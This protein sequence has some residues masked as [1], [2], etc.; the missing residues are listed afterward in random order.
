MS[1]K[2]TLSA[3]A[4]NGFRKGVKESANLIGITI[5]PKGQNVRLNGKVTNDGVSIARE[6]RFKDPLKNDGARSVIELTDKIS[7]EAGDATT[8]GTVIYESLLEEGMKKINLGPS[9]ILMRKGME[10]GLKDAVSF[11]KEMS[12]PVEKEQLKYVASVSGE[13]EEIGSI[14]ADMVQRVGSDGVITLEESHEFGLSS[15]IFQGFQFDKGYVSR[16]MATDDKQSEAIFE[17]VPILVTDQKLG[18]LDLFHAEG[19]P[20]KLI[21]KLINQKVKEL[22]IIAED[23]DPL[24]LSN[25]F[26]NRMLGI[27]KAL[28][29]KAPG[30]GDRKSEFLE[31]IAIVTGGTFFN[32]ARGIKIEDIEPEQL[33]GS[34]KVISKKDSTVIIGGKGAMEDVT[35]RV[36]QLKHLLITVKDY[37]KDK[38][39]ERIAKLSN[40]VG[41]IR[42]GGHTKKEVDY[43][44]L[45]IQN[46]INV[47]KSA[48]AD[49]II[50]G[51]GSALAMVSKRLQEGNVDVR[52]PLEVLV[53]YDVVARSMTAPLKRIAANSGESGEVIVNEVQKRGG[54]AGFDAKNNQVV[55]DMIGAGIID[56]FKA[57]RTALEIAV[58]QASIELTVG[59]TVADDPED[60]V[61]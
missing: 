59:G 54:N 14:V 9:A 61:E 60:D 24:L 53:G 34:N 47:T 23:F 4:W 46:S 7:K 16:D 10:D 21:Q 43:L 51:G 38:I 58:G 1:K 6:I 17:N 41:V 44:W 19:A 35:M 25:L 42:V 2:I 55:D 11:L 56:S 28:C 8:T 45:K 30:Y 39:Q 52:T 15:D 33:G 18:I 26:Q 3:D 37:E 48:M 12:I 29:I 40:G 49:G 50:S 31:D 20:I 22:V 36:A 57:I 13:S 32:S 27:F 5:G